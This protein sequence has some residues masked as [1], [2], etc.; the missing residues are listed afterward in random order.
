MSPPGFARRASTALKGTMLIGGQDHFYLEGQIA[1]A[2]PGE[3]DDVTV[4][5]LDPAPDRNPAHG[6]AR[7]RHRRSTR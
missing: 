7:A 5:V 2:I 6:G 1:L 4:H 3:D